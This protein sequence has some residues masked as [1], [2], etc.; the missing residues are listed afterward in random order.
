MKKIIL[1][2]LSVVTMMVLLAGCAKCI[3]TEYQNVEVNIVGEYYRGSYVTP[4]RVGKVLTMQHHPAKY[5]ITVKYNGVEYTISG[6]DTYY[7]YKDK[8][9]QTATGTLRIRTYDDGAIRYDI[10]SLE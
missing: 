8:V 1:V 2:L 4:M 3:G 7:K 9:G 10:I 5:H 6:S